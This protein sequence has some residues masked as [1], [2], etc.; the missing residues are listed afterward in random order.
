MNIIKFK[1]MLLDSSCGLSLDKIEMF[2]N[3]LKGKYAYAINW[4]HIVPL[5]KITQE[6][7]VK[8]SLGDPL[9]DG[10]YIEMIDIPQ[11]YVDLDE[12]MKIN[13]VEIY[14]NLNNQ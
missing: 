12:T 7:Y 13:G 3:E 10:I 6:E 5:D 2:N 11:H 14:K 1:D 8:L 9:I 4:M